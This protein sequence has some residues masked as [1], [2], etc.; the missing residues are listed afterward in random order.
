[1]GKRPR[2]SWPLNEEQKQL[3]AENYRLAFKF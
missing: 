2:E 3:V 1:M